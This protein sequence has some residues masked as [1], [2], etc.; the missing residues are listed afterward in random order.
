MFKVAV[1]QSCDIDAELA[2]RELGATPPRAALVFASVEL[3]HRRVLE[4]I[5]AAHPGLPLI[6]CTTDGEATSRLGFHENS[7]A[8]ALL[9]GDA[10]TVAT[11]V[12]RDV[13]RDPVERSRVAAAAAARALGRPP[14]LCVTTPESLTTSGAA[15]LEGLRAGLADIAPIVGGLAGDAVKHSGTYQFHGDEVLRD[16][17]PLLLLAGPL[18]VSVGLSSGWAPIGRRGVVSRADGHVVHEI[19]GRP[20]LEFYRHY[21]G[22]DSPSGDYPLAVFEPDG[23]GFFLRAPQR[24]DPE[25]GRVAFFG[26][27]PEGALVQLT[28]AD[29]RNI[30]AR[31]DQ[32][33]AAAVADYPAKRPAAALFFS[34][35][36]RRRVLG[37]RTAEELGTIARHVGDDVPIAGFY[38]YGELGPTAR[39]GPS[40]FHNETIVVT[41]LGE[42]DE[43][44]EAG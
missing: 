28:T 27:V 42:R 3:D 33:I 19:D 41:L 44:G 30:L 40:R 16:A 5:G 4:R 14:A 7:L 22:D 9:A 43:G 6:G 15:I 25:T 2:A 24:S 32:A 31:C 10:L 1:G 18:A 11:A 13:S 37:S 8:L 36:S 20:A 26:D 12:A 29:R 39:G 38:A 35:A 17:A 21:L 23:A 34:C